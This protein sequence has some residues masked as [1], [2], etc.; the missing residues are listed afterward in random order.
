MDETATI[1]RH[2]ACHAVVARVLGIQVKE[3]VT[4]ERPHVTTR[5]QECDLEKVVTVDL[6][7]L[8]MDSTPEAVAKDMRNAQQRAREAVLVRHGH[9]LAEDQ[10]EAEATEL[11]ARKR[12]EAADIV[13]KHDAEVGR[14][15][16]ALASGAT[17][18]QAG[19][20][21]AIAA[22]ERAEQIAAKLVEACQD[23]VEALL[24][25]S[26]ARGPDHENDL[27]RAIACIRFNQ[28]IAHDVLRRH[29]FEPRAPLVE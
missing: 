4:G 1:A 14:V 16:A 27:E 11:L 7:G 2:E 26:E 24:Q 15:A 8:A 6:A 21:D 13:F 20:D 10:L 12:A 5:Y 23:F 17:L 18:G 25:I 29:G 19:I 22:P 28:R 3:A 9:D